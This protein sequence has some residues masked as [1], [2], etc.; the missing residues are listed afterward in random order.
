MTLPRWTAGLALA[1]ALSCSP[2]QA[3]PAPPPTTADEFRVT[4]LGTGSPAPVMRRFGPGVLVEAGGKK[5]LIDSGRGTTQ[6]LLQV[7][8]TLGELT[9]ADA[10]QRGLFD[11]GE[12]LDAREEARRLALSQAMDRVNKRF[13]RD[14]V[15]LGHDSAGAA[16]S[17][18][19]RIAFTRIPEIAE[20]HE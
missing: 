12:T 1:T 16:R 11:T 15:T 5:L 8:V 13:G 20:F 3:Q 10:V 14:A 7:G 18:G 6:R 2:L 4:L 19:P 17:Q 9:A